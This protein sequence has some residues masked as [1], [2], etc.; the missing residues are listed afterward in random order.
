MKHR[1]QL[2]SE[3]QQQQSAQAEATQQQQP[4][5]REF[6]S[7]EEALRHDAAHTVVPAAIAERLRES[8]ASSP[9]PPRS[10]WK[11]FFGGTNP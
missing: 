8:V 1:S 7:P 9:A 11:R 3:Q 4:A 6:A 5:A 10:W 2:N